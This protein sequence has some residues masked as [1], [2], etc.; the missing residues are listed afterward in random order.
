M[1]ITRNPVTAVKMTKRREG[2]DQRR[3][4]Q[5]WTVDDARWFPRIGLA[6]PAKR[7][8][9]AFVLVLVLGLRPGEEGP[10]PSLESGRPGRRLSCT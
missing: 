2:R 9:A 5:T 1:T 3:K 8:T 4:R 7:S 10:R 6:R